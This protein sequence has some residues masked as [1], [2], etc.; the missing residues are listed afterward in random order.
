VACRADDP[1]FAL[2]DFGAPDGADALAIAAQA[3]GV[4]LKILRLER[5]ESLYRSQL[6]VVRPD[7][8]IAWH[9]D[10]VAEPMAIIDRVR[11][12]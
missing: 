4:P 9:G 5:P 3:R 8:H 1:D 7:Q 10:A 2:L 11:G 6:V 12:A